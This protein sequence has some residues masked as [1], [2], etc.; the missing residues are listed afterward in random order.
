[1]LDELDAMITSGR[2]GVIDLSEQLDLEIRALRCVLL[3]EVGVRNGL[4]QVAGEAQPIGRGSGGEPEPGY[5]VPGCG[6]VGAQGSLRLG[7]RVGSRDVQ[8]SSEI[9]RRPTRA[10]GAGADDRHAMAGVLGI[11][12][13][14]LSSLEADVVVDDRAR[15]N[16]QFR[17]LLEVEPDELEPVLPDLSQQLLDEFHG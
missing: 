13:G 17:R 9:V 7:G 16:R 11:R 12:H 15:G 3:H 2:R 1:M 5:G 6:Y 14:S 4:P 8:A 10:D